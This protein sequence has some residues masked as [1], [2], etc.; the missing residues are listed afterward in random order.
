MS[1]PG[2][3][4]QGS[5]NLRDNWGVGYKHGGVYEVTSPKAANGAM[6]GCWMKGRLKKGDL[7]LCTGHSGDYFH[8]FILLKTYSN[9]WEGI[10]GS[11][12]GAYGSIGKLVHTVGDRDFDT[13]VKGEFV[14]FEETKKIDHTPAF[15]KRQ[16]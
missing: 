11:E 13:L 8:N 1:I 6:G 9:G 4:N 2:Y 3:N 14:D 5:R 7:L 16:R 12:F 10:T 15:L